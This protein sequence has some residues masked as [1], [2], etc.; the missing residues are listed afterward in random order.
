[1]CVWISISDAAELT[2]LDV[3]VVV[4]FHASVWCKVVDGDIASN[5]LTVLVLLRG[6]GKKLEVAVPSRFLTFGFKGVILFC[7]MV[8]RKAVLQVAHSLRDFCVLQYLPLLCLVPASGANQPMQPGIVFMP[9][10]GTNDI[11]F[12]V[13]CELS[14]CENKKQAGWST[15]TRR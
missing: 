10:V 4:V 11:N 8:C 12:V 13:H 3:T 14:L 2:R 6:F 9:T 15:R 5:H 1:M 7:Y